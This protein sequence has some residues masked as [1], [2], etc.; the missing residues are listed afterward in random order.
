MADGCEEQ[1][2]A[3]SGSRQGKYYRRLG[4]VY[5]VINHFQL[6]FFVKQNEISWHIYQHSVAKIGFLAENVIWFYLQ[7][8]TVNI[9][10][11]TTPQSAFFVLFF[12]SILSF[13]HNAAS[14][15]HINIDCICLDTWHTKTGEVAEKE[16]GK[17]GR[18]YEG[19]RRPCVWPSVFAHSQTAGQPPHPVTLT[20]THTLS[21]RWPALSRDGDL[22]LLEVREKVEVKWALMSPT[23]RTVCVCVCVGLKM[24]VGVWPANWG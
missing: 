2:M 20:H 11:H 13:Y 10:R 7:L 8:R 17:R 14:H 15:V 16:D 21:P 1:G 3:G 23:N 12:V 9:C 19:W 6:P 22:N 4:G 24:G 18:E 5:M